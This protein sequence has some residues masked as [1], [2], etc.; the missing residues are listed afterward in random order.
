MVPLRGT[1]PTPM[2]TH[3][4]GQFVDLGMFR[5]KSYAERPV[6]AYVPSIV[7]PAVAH[8]LL[9]LFDGQNVFGDHGSYAGGWHAHDAVDRLTGRKVIAPIVVG[10]H[11]GGVDRIHEMG[12]DVRWFVEAVAGVVLPRIM[13]EFHIAGPEHRVIGG[14]S[15]GGLAALYTLF[16]QPTAFG[17]AIA[18]SP[19][20][21]F[22]RREFLRGVASGDLP[23]PPLS[24]IYLDA[25]ARERG[26]MFADAEQLAKILAPQLQHAGRFMWRPDQRGAH[27]ESHWRRRLPKA[28]RFMFQRK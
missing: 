3:P 18:M 26:R 19:S 5:P 12:R 9:V 10:I 28:L 22:A 4:R 25:G 21:W 13:H 8:P 11:N 6:R 14:S 20:L 1:M 15:L 7:D 24:R 27:H 23:I 17:A 16:E 2:R